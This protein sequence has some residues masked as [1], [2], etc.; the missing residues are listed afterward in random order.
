MGNL[1]SK[2]R[3]QKIFLLPRNR[4]IRSLNDL[5]VL[6]R[7]TSQAL[8]EMQK[9]V[10]ENKD[11]NAIEFEAPA[12]TGET[13]L[14]TR[15]ANQLSD[16][17]DL[18]SAHGIY[19]QFLVSAV[20]RTEDY[21]QEVLKIVLKWFPEKLALAIDGRQ[22]EKNIPLDVLLESSTVE[23]IMDKIIEKY[24]LSAFYGSPER[25]FDHAQSIL[26][27]KIEEELRES[28]AEIK[29]ARDIIIHNSGIA[30]EIYVS[31][32]GTKARAH[33]AQRLEIDQKYFDGAIHIM[34]KLTHSVYSK[35][36]ERF[37]NYVPRRKSK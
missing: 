19:E 5:Y 9:R 36:L 8:L 2:R 27:I 24:L 37:G 29:A 17:L 32:A 35:T 13:T 18:A 11:D 15:D 25:Y 10:I 4:T 1:K 30:N 22:V 14:L 20:A 16:L 21:L 28:F 31:R 7:L 12:A 26:S 3:N 34:K 6:V 23:E 33:S